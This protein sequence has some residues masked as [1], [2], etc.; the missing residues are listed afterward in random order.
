MTAA[1]N[2]YR[3]NRSYFVTDGAAGPATQYVALTRGRDRNTA[4]VALNTP[5]HEPGTAPAAVTS[6]GG[7]VE[8]DGPTAQPT[9]RAVL[10]TGLGTTLAVSVAVDRDSQET[11]QREADHEQFAA[12]AAAA[13]RQRRNAAEHDYLDPT[14]VSSVDAKI[15]QT[16]A[17]N[18]F[19][20]RPSRRHAALRAQTQRADRPDR[21]DRQRA[22]SSGQLPAT[23]RR[24]RVLRGPLLRLTSWMT[25]AAISL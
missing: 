1:G 21:S 3:F 2:P 12:R 6:T 14:T 17:R 18:S 9:A 19:P 15:L 22:R 24:Y 5:R 7:I 25:P 8:L 23:G 13:V 11:A 10:E 20:P 16:P 4:I